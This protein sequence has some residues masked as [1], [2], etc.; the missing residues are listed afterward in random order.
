V[1]SSKITPWKIYKACKT[2]FTRQPVPSSLTLQDGS[3]ATSVKETTNALLHKFFPD[4]STERDNEKH[5]KIRAQITDL[6]PLDSQPEPNFTE[7]EVDEVIS[8]L[9]ESK[10]PGP[11]GID[12]N[13]VKR[14]RK[15][16]P[17]FWMALFNKC[18]ALGC[19]PTVCK[20]A[21]VI[22]IPKADKTKLRSVEGYRG[23]SLLS[24][25]EKCLEKLVN[26]RLNYFLETS[27]QIS[28]QFGLTAGRSTAEDIKTV[29]EFVGHSRKR[30]LKC[31]LLVLDIAGAFDNA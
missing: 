17:K 5:K 1:E 11:D 28:L 26:E 21:R 29:S 4:D 18:Y 24:I 15:Y 10:C 8:K 22:A 7:H 23:I 16:L 27:G 25:P 12:G 3:T 31:C 2:D 9:D 19:F 6:M 13:I 20:N 30:G 14:L